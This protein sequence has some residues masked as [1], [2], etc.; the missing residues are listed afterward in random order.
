MVRIQNSLYSVAGADEREHTRRFLQVRRKVFTAHGGA[1][2]QQH[3]GPKRAMDNPLKARAGGG[4]VHDGPV[5]ALDGELVARAMRIADALDDTFHQF[6]DAHAQRRIERPNGSREHGRTGNHIEGSARVELRHRHHHRIERVDM[7]RHDVLQR[8]HHLRTNGNRIDGHVRNGRMTTVTNNGALETVGRGHC[9]SGDDT[10]AT[11]RHRC[12]QMNADHRIHTIHHALS[13]HLLGAAGR[14]FFGVLK[15]EAYFARELIAVLREQSGERQHDGCMPVMAT[16]VHGPVY[17]R[18]PWHVIFFVNRERIHVG[19]YCDYTPRRRAEKSRHHTG[20][21]GARDYQSGNP[22][23][24]LTN[25][26]RGFMLV[27]RDFWPLV[28]M[29]TPGN[30]LLRHVAGLVE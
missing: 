12:P 10:D 11:H 2:R 7:T 24:H 21:G 6:G 29:P 14:E 23:Q 13:H 5:A 30:D 9:G 16:G 22:A 8:G 17:L 27:E 18:T 26:S 4:I 20:F 19:A 3:V 1:C 25:E 15:H 28:E